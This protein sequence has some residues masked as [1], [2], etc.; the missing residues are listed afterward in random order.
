MNDNNA[1]FPQYRKLSN[2]RA[3]YKIMNAKRFVE[4]QL[5][6]KKCFTHEIIAHQYPEMLRI[7]DML[8]AEEPFEQSNEQEFNS[9]SHPANENT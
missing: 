9:A 1:D 3:F 6:G 7:M 8:K 4:V 2:G 5:M